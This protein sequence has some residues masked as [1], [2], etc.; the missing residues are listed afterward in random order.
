MQRGLAMDFLTP[1]HFTWLTSSCSGTHFSWL[2]ILLPRSGRPY[3]QTGRSVYLPGEA[4]WV[5]FHTG[6][7][8]SPGAANVSFKLSE[9]PVF[10]QAGSIVVLGPE[11]QFVDDRQADP[12]EVRVYRGADAT[13]TLYEER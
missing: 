4:S 12:L 3:K 13:F 1:L 11:L 9:A 8:L 7:S 10:V 5:N 6:L 2:P